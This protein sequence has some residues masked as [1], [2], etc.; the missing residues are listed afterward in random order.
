MPLAQKILALTIAI[1]FSSAGL[2]HSI[3]P[4]DDTHALADLSAACSA[5][6]GFG[7]CP[8]NFPATPDSHPHESTLWDFIH[9]ALASEGKHL[10]SV[11]PRH[12]D[13]GFL[14][15]VAIALSFVP[16]RRSRTLLYERQLARGVFAFRRFG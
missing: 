10:A 13:F 5:I 16:I 8:A 12:S 2:L 6:Y 14:A 11:L 7:H 3:V 9:G 15:I 1:S 4:H